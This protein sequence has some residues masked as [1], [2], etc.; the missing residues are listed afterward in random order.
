MCTLSFILHP[1]PAVDTLTRQ[2]RDILFTSRAS[3]DAPIT[4]QKLA[5]RFQFSRTPIRGAL[6][7]LEEEGLIERRKKKGIYLR[8]PSIKEL[9]EVYEVRA[10]LEGFAGRLAVRNATRNDIKEL[11]SW[12]RQFTRS[13]ERRDFERAERANVAFHNKIVELAG[14]TVL[15]NMM[16]RFA[17]VRRAFRLTHTIPA[18]RMVRTT[19]YPHEAIV[20]RI[21]AGDADG[22]EKLLQ[23]HIRRGK[24]LLIERVLDLDLEIPQLEGYR[25]LGRREGSS[26]R[27]EGGSEH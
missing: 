9:A 6:R 3:R 18:E 20:D 25:V 21:E 23:L 13:R 10:V 24:Q 11:R 26:T 8:R 19:P 2:I 1:S 4:E 27:R 17:I 16:E 22:A 15:E 12:A 14:N 5:D 7:V